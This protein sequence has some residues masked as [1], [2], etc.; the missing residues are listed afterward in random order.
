MELTKYVESV[1][2][3]LQLIVF[4]CIITGSLTCHLRSHPPTQAYFEMMFENYDQRSVFET[5][6]YFFIYITTFFTSCINLV[7]SNK[8]RFVYH[9]VAK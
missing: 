3:F 1:L 2:V 7:G 4:F 5:E 6:E 8:R 9:F